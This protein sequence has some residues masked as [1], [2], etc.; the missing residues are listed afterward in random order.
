MTEE[1]H[2]FEISDSLREKLLVA[3]KKRFYFATIIYL[4]DNLQ[5][6]FGPKIA[7]FYYYFK[8]A[9][10]NPE[11]SVGKTIIAD[12]VFENMLFFKDGSESIIP[13]DD[14]GTNALNIDFFKPMQKIWNVADI[15]KKAILSLQNRREIQNQ[16]K[17]SVIDKNIVL[18]FTDINGM[19][20]I[21]ESNVNLPDGYK[22]LYIICGEGECNLEN[23]YDDICLKSSD[24]IY[25]LENK[26]LS[27][28]SRT[29]VKGNGNS[30]IDNE[31]F[32][33]EDRTPVRIRGLFSQGSEGVILQTYYKCFLAK[34]FFSDNKQDIQGKYITETY[35]NPTGMTRPRQLLYD[36]KGEVRGYL[37]KKINGIDLNEVVYRPDYYYPN[38]DLPRKEIIN[39]LLHRLIEYN[40]KKLFF[41]DLSLDNFLIAFNNGINI[42]FADCSSISTNNEDIQNSQLADLLWSIVSSGL[43][44]EQFFTP[45]GQKLCCETLDS[46]VVSAFQYSFS[47]NKS[48]RGKFLSPKE[49]LKIFS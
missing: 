44:A 33:L 7:S 49:W 9:G 15:L 10:K 36:D 31:V 13:A 39:V 42:F 17:Y 47:P 29:F 28:I 5:A 18:I 20:K 14:Y 4:P 6:V 48:G 38:G 11:T 37:I 12:V 19:G 46:I 24:D 8:N 35:I 22:V 30:V 26:L 40:S 41:D 16:E 45:L 23:M 32:Y 34:I 21:I 3:G 1:G 2:L 25:A 43:S 27:L